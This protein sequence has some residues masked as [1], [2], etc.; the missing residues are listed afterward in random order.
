MP[1][2]SMRRAQGDTQH[3]TQAARAPAFS[4]ATSYPNGLRRCKLLA[5][6]PTHCCGS[7]AASI[8]LAKHHRTSKSAGTAP[9]S[10]GLNLAGA[11]FALER[12]Y[13]Q[14]ERAKRASA[15]IDDRYMTRPTSVFY[16]V[17]EA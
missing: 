11:R 7:R 14:P 5:Y 13:V 4:I 10:R 17:R 8:A 15:E 2:L 12:A 6:S 1:K 16:G 9:R 3:H